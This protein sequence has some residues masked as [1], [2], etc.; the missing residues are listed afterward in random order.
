MTGRWVQVVPD[1]SLAD[2]AKAA[3]DRIETAL[4]SFS[5]DRAS[6]T[7]VEIVLGDVRMVRDLLAARPAPDREREEVAQELEATV[8]SDWLGPM[9]LEMLKRAARLLRQSTP[10]REPEGPMKLL[11]EMYASFPLIQGYNDRQKQLCEQ[12]HAMLAAAPT[13]SDK[14]GT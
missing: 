2:R 7:R 9:D 4:H 6:Q 11:R 13:G 5:I 14:E 8:A 3:L 10:A 12:V 1:D